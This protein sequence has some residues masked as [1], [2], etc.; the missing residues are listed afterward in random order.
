[1]YDTR[2]V[3]VCYVLNSKKVHIVDVVRNFSNGA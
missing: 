1:M 3:G 2:Y